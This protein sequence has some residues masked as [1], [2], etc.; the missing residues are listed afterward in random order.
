M[1]KMMMVGDHVRRVEWRKEEG[2]YE[3]GEEVGGEEEE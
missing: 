1:K 3:D 2:V